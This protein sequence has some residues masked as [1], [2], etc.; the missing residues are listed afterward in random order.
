VGHINHKEPRSVR[1]ARLQKETQIKGR[2]DDGEAEIATMSHSFPRLHWIQLKHIYL[3]S[4]RDVQELR[5]DN[6]RHV[7]GE[8]ERQRRGFD[9]GFPDRAMAAACTTYLFTPR[10]VQE[11]RMTGICMRIP[12]FA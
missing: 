4:E 6:C 8:I 11:K 3:P 7:L 5:A 9:R 2:G 1:N 10:S 12:L